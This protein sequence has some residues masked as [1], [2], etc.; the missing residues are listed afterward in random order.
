MA[1]RREDAKNLAEAMNYYQTAMNNYAKFL[2]LYTKE[3]IYRKTA[4]EHKLI[5]EA[6][7]Q[8]LEGEK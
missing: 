7:I 4:I 5:C 6:A 2:M 8:R 3:D 1:Q